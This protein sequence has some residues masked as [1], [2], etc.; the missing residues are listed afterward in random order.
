M[1]LER[2]GYLDNS[3]IVFTSDHGDCLGDHG[4]SQKW[5]MYEQITR[6]PMIVWAP[7]RVAQGHQVDSLTQQMDIVPALLN[8]GG[9]ETPEMFECISAQSALEGKD[10]E[11]REYAY[12]EQSRDGILQ[13]TEFMTMVRSKDWKLVHFLGEDFGQLFDLDNDPGEVDN[14]WDDPSAQ[15]IKRKMMDHLLAWRMESQHHTRNFSKE[16]R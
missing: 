6:V 9:I 7:G 14:K 11:N 3:I 12:C 4:H 1:P 13:D 5:T 15:G 10:L 2:K 8:Y 16:H